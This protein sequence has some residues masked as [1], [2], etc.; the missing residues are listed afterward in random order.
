MINLR[1]AHETAPRWRERGR[2]IMKSASSL[3]SNRTA[4]AGRGIAFA[5]AVL[6]SMTACDSL[7]EV[8]A[9]GTVQASDLDNPALATTLL[10]SALGR[11]ECAYTSY[12]VTTGTMAHEFINSSGWLNLHPWGA[13][14]E[15]IE[16]IPG[17]CPGGRDATNL[18]AYSPLQTARY[19][20][21]HATT[22][23]EGFPDEQVPNKPQ[24]LGLL[25]AYGGFSYVLL[26]EGFCEMAID[27]GPRMSREDVFRVAEERFTATLTHAQAAGDDDLRLLALA[28]RAR[29]RLDLGDMVGAAA[30]A[31][32]IPEGFVWN[33]EYST[34]DGVRENRIF[35]LNRRNRFLSVGPE[36]QALLIG[37]EADT[38]VPAVSS[39]VAGHDNA[40]IH[41]YQHKYNAAS[42]PIPMASW[43]EAQLIIAEARPAETVAAIN[44]LRAA[45]DLP[46]LT[47][48]GGENHIDLV[49][50]ERR[51]QL[52][53]EGHRLNDM[54]RH[55][56]PFPT[57]LNHKL[58]AY[59][60]V[61][62]IPLPLLERQNNPNL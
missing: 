9:P 1:H 40:T 59:G 21:E 62:C 55:N 4:A 29:A 50:E 56:L 30:D 61:T 46:P 35:N 28:G 13:L 22:L 39:G 52:Y 25:A 51:R 38:R 32:L 48:S 23:I 54:L 20:T 15:Q 26:G 31:E 41:W 16:E 33:A 57:G 47:V 6:V 42:D 58:Q 27:Q 43:E 18:G 44:R 60:P 24:M 36:Y 53:M 8:E 17:N 11:F 5:L 19:L 2:T 37:A 7:L 10:N 34:V 49:L 45:Q 12:V 14:W 3:R